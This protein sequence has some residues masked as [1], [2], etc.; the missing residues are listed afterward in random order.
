MDQDKK[1]TIQSAAFIAMALLTIISVLFS[2]KVATAPHVL[3]ENITNYNDKSQ[4]QAMMMLPS[5]QWPFEIEYFSYQKPTKAENINYV[6]IRDLS[7][8]CL[9]WIANDPYTNLG[10]TIIQC[11]KKRI[12][13]KKY[14]K[15][16]P[17]KTN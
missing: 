7:S 8:R 4:W 1:Q 2:W 13:L 6:I 3:N 16:L 11:F 17:K 9:F 14:T 10:E 5:E 15:E 12:D